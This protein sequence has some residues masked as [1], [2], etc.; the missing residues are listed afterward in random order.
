LGG[1]RDRGADI[2]LIATVA[3]FENAITVARLTRE[4][5]ELSANTSVATP[6]DGDSGTLVDSVVTAIE[7]LGDLVGGVLV[8][9]PSRP[10]PRMTV[11]VD[12]LNRLRAKP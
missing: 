9:A 10:D 3:P 4:Q 5:P 12:G 11:L 1:V 6:H 8:H 2:P 7:K